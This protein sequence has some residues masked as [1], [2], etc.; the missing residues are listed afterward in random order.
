[1]AA[2]RIRMSKTESSPFHLVPVPLSPP[3]LVN[4][5]GARALSPFKA[6]ARPRKATLAPSDP[7]PVPDDVRPAGPVRRAAFPT[8]QQSPPRDGAALVRRRIRSNPDGV[9]WKATQTRRSQLTA[10]ARSRSA[11]VLPPTSVSP[12][13][14]VDGGAVPPC[15]FA[16][17]EGNGCS[18]SVQFWSLCVCV[19]VLSPGGVE[20]TPP[21]F[22]MLSLQSVRVPPLSCAVS[23]VSVLRVL[24]VCFAVCG[25][26][27][28]CVLRPLVWCLLLSAYSIVC[29]H[30]LLVICLFVCRLMPLCLSCSPHCR[31]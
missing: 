5:S 19:R 11:A 20:S 23:S 24:R 9:E 3:K 13:L 1:M 12:L 17:C 22:S 16:L 28:C 18:R 10:V 15:E 25:V 27:L 21:D 2:R 4:G 14:S 30:L 7:P 31:I 29:L 8:R 6:A 26:L